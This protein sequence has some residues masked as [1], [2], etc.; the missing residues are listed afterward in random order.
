M[1]SLELDRRRFVKR[2]EVLR[3]N[4]ESALERARNGEYA[5][6]CAVKFCVISLVD[7]W[8]DF[9]RS[10]ILSSAV[11]GVRTASGAL[12]P[13]SPIRSKSAALL[14]AKTNTKGKIG[15]E[16]RWHDADQSI[17]VAKKLNIANFSNYSLAVGDANSPADQ[18][19]TVRNFFCHERSDCA[20][21]LRSAKWFSKSMDLS[22]VGVSGIIRKDGRVNFG[23]WVDELQLISS[24][25][26][27]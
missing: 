26:V 25:C 7:C 16:P 23:F 12:L 22:P 6:S 21:K 17:A 27:N 4:F 10:V 24:L 5:S 1:S 20:E 14:A 15:N 9:H 11:G 19:R 13:S 8:S 3:A 2:T 18:V